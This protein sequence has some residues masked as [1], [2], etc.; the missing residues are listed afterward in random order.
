ME[1][2]PEVV[3]SK[4][5]R[6]R[7]VNAANWTKNRA[8]EE[9]YA[10]KHLPVKP[11]CEH[12][13]KKLQ[14]SKIPLQD[15][16]KL[17]ESFY[18]LK[19][20]LKQDSFILKHVKGI[21]TKRRRPRSESRNYKPRG[22]QLKYMIYCRSQVQMMQVCQ[23]AFLQVLQI[24]RYRV[25]NVIKNYHLHGKF[26]I[27]KRGGDRMSHKFKDKKENVIKFIKTFK[28]S[29][30]HY[31]RGNSRRMY[32]PSE[33]SIN[34]MAKMYNDQAQENLKVKKL[35]F[36]AIFNTIFNLG[37]GSPRVDVC[38]TC[39]QLNEK[40][41]NVQNDSDKAT[42]IAEKTV[43]KRRANEFFKML[44]EDNRKIKIFS[45]DCQKNMPLPK[46]PD[47]STY[48]SRQLY[49]YNFT[50]VEGNSK[51]ALTKENVFSYCWTED[52]FAKDANLIVS[53]VYHR[54]CNTDFPPECNQVRLMADGCT[55]QNKNSMLIAMLSCWL[56]K[57]A[58]A[59]I[60]LVEVVFPVV[61][62]SFLPPDRVFA[63][64]EKEL[65]KLENIIKPKE[66]FDVVEKHSTAI[67]VATTVQVC[68]WKTVVKD[69]FMITTKWHVPFSKCKRFYLK[70]ASKSND[71][72]GVRGELHYR[73]ESG[74][75]K[76]VC[77][78]GK[79]MAMISPTA[80]PQG[81][82]VKPL[83][84]RDVNKLLFTHFG[85]KWRDLEILEYYN[86]VLPSTQ[87][88]PDENMV[89]DIDFLEESVCEE[90]EESPLLII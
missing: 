35:Y 54:L 83:K 46:I 74:Q 37:F 38:S 25:E 7:R 10:A 86:R 12:K 49:F 33:L 58:P 57:D 67:N 70:R 19:D 8:K 56:T 18:R 61:G 42:L 44:K 1:C 80:I 36:R 48:Y 76:S 24:K 87:E 69:I 60:H 88:I 55:G 31:C 65:R 71:M 68:N 21:K 47:Q 81:A 85:D 72:V 66:Y 73:F 14:C 43:H 41:K 45:F 50:I 26:P 59:Q 27:E 52:E 3:D 75:Y 22:L 40:I 53:S 89:D 13:C 64:I 82:Q 84:F 23:K 62:H 79:N 9:R 90:Q 16:R 28:C 15:V 77:K 20:K 39:L 17:H 30:A 34:K 11:T 32:L 51:S 4:Q 5:A 78:K 6:K 63:R 29:E 2:Y